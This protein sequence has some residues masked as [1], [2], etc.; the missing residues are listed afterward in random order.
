MQDLDVLGAGRA[1]PGVL[2]VVAR[3]VHCSWY[4]LLLVFALR[5][6]QVGVLQLTVLCGLGSW[7][8]CGVVSDLH[9]AA[10]TR[11]RTS[12]ISCVRAL[13]ALVRQKNFERRAPAII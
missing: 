12:R 1:A 13:D 10:K 2:A 3:A 4:L 7:N 6:L 5:R 11:R 8:K 9:R